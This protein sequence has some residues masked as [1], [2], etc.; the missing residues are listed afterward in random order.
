MLAVDDDPAYRRYL[1]HLLR[2]AGFEITTSASASDALDR[3]RG[4]EE[5]DMLIVDLSMPE[6]TGLEFVAKLGNDQRTAGMYKILL[7]AYGETETKLRALDGGLDDFLTKSSSEEEILAKL[8]SA[9]RRLEMER[10]LHLENEELQE[11]VLTDELTGIGNRRAL[12]REGEQLARSG[13][14]VSM[15]LF[16]IDAFKAINDTYGHLHGDRVLIEVAATLKKH[17]RY[18]DILAR[19][20]GDEFVLV[21]PDTGGAEA[22]RI[23]NRIAA[24][25]RELEW[26]TE[27]GTFRTA[28]SCGIST[29]TA[30]CALGELLKRSDAQLYSRKRSLEARP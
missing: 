23:A 19:F 22:R 20:G 25:V 17:T 24:A 16:D 5:V 14:R 29:V 30:S 7:T 8:R 21:L 15:I 10:R 26:Q 18:G 9:A 13:R 1:Q 2:K 11:L 28:V 4:G 6:M 12:Y 3:I 27:K